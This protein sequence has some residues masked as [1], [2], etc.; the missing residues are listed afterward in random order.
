QHALHGGGARPDLAGAHQ[1]RREGEAENPA[2]Q[3]DERA[4]LLSPFDQSAELGRNSTVR[5]AAA[6]SAS[7]TALAKARADL[8]G[9]CLGKRRGS[10][11]TMRPLFG[12]TL[13]KPP[14]RPISGMMCL[15]RENT[16]RMLADCSLKVS[17][18]S[19]SAANSSSCAS[20]NSRTKPGSTMWR[21]EITQQLRS[22]SQ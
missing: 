12:S 11:G 19:Q 14:A 21:F 17:N 15:L 2:G 3:R 20:T 13:K 16:R 7:L 22:K 1:Q 8:K 18:S 5:S 4:A 9:P 10:A 6:A